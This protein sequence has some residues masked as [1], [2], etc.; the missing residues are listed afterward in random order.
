MAELKLPGNP[1][2]G[3]IVFQKGLVLVVATNEVSQK[4]LVAAV[5]VDLQECY[6]R[7]CPRSDRLL[8]TYI[9]ALRLTKMTHS[10]NGRQE[11][12]TQVSV[13]DDFVHFDIQSLRLFDSALDHA[14][15][16]KMTHS[17]NVEKN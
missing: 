7:L 1:A 5:P 14:G 3:A 8:H 13:R 10:Q 17:Q 4:L 15:G 2:R 16:T 12:L 6:N 11:K 9:K